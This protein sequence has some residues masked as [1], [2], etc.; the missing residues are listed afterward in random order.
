VW[1]VDD[2]FEGD[3]FNSEGN[4]ATK[5]SFSLP[6]GTTNG[7]NSILLSENLGAPGSDPFGHIHGRK[8]SASAPGLYMVTVQAYDASHNG[9]GGGPIHEPSEPL[10]IFF[11][12]GS[13]ISALAINDGQVAVSFPAQLGTDYIVE[14]AAD[15]GDPDGWEPVAG[16]V[17]GH[18]SFQVVTDDHWNAARRFY[19]LRLSPTL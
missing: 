11:Q 15:L 14:A 19:R 12:A 3:D 18:D 4:H 6:S 7:T 5:V 1:D 10:S 13:G 2:F 9:P 16:P 17:S 8:I